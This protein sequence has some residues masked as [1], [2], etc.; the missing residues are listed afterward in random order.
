M[1]E[2]CHEPA[3]GLG[4]WVGPGNPHFIHAHFDKPNLSGWCIRN[5]ALANNNQAHLSPDSADSCC[6]GMNA[7]CDIMIWLR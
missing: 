7:G 2:A 3:Q 6:G 1:K 5:K 4:D